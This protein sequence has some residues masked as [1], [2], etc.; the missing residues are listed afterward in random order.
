MLG[1]CSWK[2]ARYHQRE[3]YPD[4]DIKLVS[5]ISCW[6]FVIQI[7]PLALRR[8]RKFSGFN[9]ICTY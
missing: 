2:K 9:F 5:A 1:G 4:E 6:G 8:M 3:Q 7:L